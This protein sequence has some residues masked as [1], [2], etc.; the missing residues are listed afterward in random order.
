MFCRVFFFQAEDGIRDRLV[1][2]VQTCAL[3]IWRRGDDS[4]VSYLTDLFPANQDDME[5]ISIYA[6]ALGKLGAI[7]ELEALECF[8]AVRYP[9]SQRSQSTA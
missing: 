5:F 2:G 4:L 6:F 8:I 9:N 3:P 1:T 7:A